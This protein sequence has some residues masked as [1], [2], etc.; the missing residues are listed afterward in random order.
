MFAA[1]VWNILSSFSISYHNLGEWETKRDGMINVRSERRPPVGGR[2]IFHWQ[3]RSE[4]S[5]DSL[6]ACVGGKT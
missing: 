5:T 1:H 4:P 6:S 3:R 2:A